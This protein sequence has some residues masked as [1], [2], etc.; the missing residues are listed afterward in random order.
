MKTRLIKISILIAIIV[1]FCFEPADAQVL[2][3]GTFKIGRTFGLID[4]WYVDSVNM[5]ELT[6]KAIVEILKNLD[7]HSVYISAK[8]VK[9]MNEPLNGNFDG[10]GIQF[11]LLHD[12][13]I[14]VEPIAG[15]PS[16]KAGLRPGDRII[17]IDG[18]NVAGKGIST[19]GVRTRLMGTRGTKVSIRI[20][21]KGEAG[22]LDFTLTRDRIPINSLDA[23]YM[24]DRETGYIRLN[25]FAITTDSEFTDAI[26]ILIK[27]RM[28]N[29]VL[30]LRGNGGGI[31]AASTSLLEKFF[32]DKK[33]MVYLEGRKTPRQDY[34]SAG[35][36]SLASARIVVLVD[37][38]SA[39]ASEIVAGAL[40]DWDRG[41]I[42]GRPTFGKGLVQHGY[43]LTDGSMIRLTVARYYTPTGRS[44]QSPYNEGYDKYMENYYTR[45]SNSGLTGDTIAIPDSLSFKTMV[46][47]RTV[48]G[49]GGIMPDVFVPVDTSGYSDYYRNLV[50]RGVI[51]SFALEFFDQNRSRLTSEYKNFDDFRE[52]FS[53][54]EKD[55][56]DFIKEGEKAGVKYDDEQFNISKKEILVVLKA[57]VATN[58]WQ[59][60]EYFR[61]VNEDD[62]V[63][64]KALELI[65]DPAAYNN[66]L[67]GRKSGTGL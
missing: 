4:A 43:Y 55:I 59:T 26:E 25:K 50:R 44:I 61:L 49:G 32:S 64:K 7:P 39:S 10:I 28:K 18:E 60:N 53:F 11:N 33:L 54:S 35:G 67:E 51:N 57:V 65:S 17:E 62:K 1:S 37:E 46:S 34:N 8:D 27:S 6:E 5:D 63:I 14:V 40:Q 16:E 21:R 36:G 24:L 2:N 47:K 23:A 56:S 45:L 22:I 41:V 30:D 38:N 13:I 9:E 52:K 66:I 3:E 58:M 19:A 42:I 12:S 31:M 15:G 48:Y 20:F 29:L